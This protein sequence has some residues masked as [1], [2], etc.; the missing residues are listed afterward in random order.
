MLRGQM[1][2]A[3]ILIV[4]DVHGLWRPEDAA[5]IENGNQ[6]LTLFVGD[7]GDEDVELV[8]SIAALKVPKAIILGNHDAWR[9]FSNKGATDQLRQSIQALGSDHLAY[10]VRELPE[11]GLSLIGARPFSWGGMDLRSAE[12]YGEFFGVHTPEESADRIVRA[13]QEAQHRDVV[14]LAHN[15]PYGLSSDPSGIYGKDFGRRPGGDWGDRDLAWALPRIADLG[16]RVQ[17]VIAG[18]MHDR[19]HR[20]IGG[21]RRRFVRMGGISFINPAVVPRIRPHDGT[22]L[23][24][25]ARTTWVRGEL[26]AIEEIWLDSH[27]E[28]RSI[29]VPTFERLPVRAG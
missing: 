5:F 11:A 23:R 1:T 3:E 28:I 9:S 10:S 21:F 14:I 19:L 25:F 27:N 8:R 20:Q 26:H 24:H 15:G 7:L 18:H 16:L 13:A 22:E 6:D 12:V 4:G 17:A 2:R 29:D